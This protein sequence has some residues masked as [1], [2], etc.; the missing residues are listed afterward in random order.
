M[1]WLRRSI[2]VLAAAACASS[3]AACDP[4]DDEMSGGA[5]PVDEL[6]PT[7]TPTTTPGKPDDYDNIRHD[8]G[9]TIP[10]PAPT[11]DPSV[12]RSFPY[13][14]I[15]L[16]V[17]EDSTFDVAQVERTDSNV[18]LV[19]VRN[20][21]MVTRGTLRV[22]AT[23]DRGAG[24]RETGRQLRVAPPVVNPGEWAVSFV[25]FETPVPES[26]PLTTAVSADHVAPSTEDDLPVVSVRTAVM[27]GTGRA[28][29]VRGVV[30][31][32]RERTIEDLVVDLIC[33]S[34]EGDVTFA[35]VPVV[36]ELPAGHSADYE[37]PVS[38][39]PCIEFLVVATGH[40]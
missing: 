19:F 35:T 18:V 5:I 24:K 17:R 14:G 2:A 3:L 11:D 27:T 4:P 22:T 15:P 21:T 37:A 7:P 39:N 28:T 32:Q 10:P 34:A 29:A 33:F 38:T 26:T 12:F 36:E 20:H 9:V 23:A 6:T 31:N 8:R 40:F 16:A 13:A 25:L 30:A 1:R